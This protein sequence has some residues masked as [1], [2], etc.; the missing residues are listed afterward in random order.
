MAAPLDFGALYAEHRT[1]AY[2]AALALVPAGEADDIVAEA[3]ARVLAV[4]QAGGGPAGAFRPYLLAAVRNIARDRAAERRRVISVADLA[5]R[6]AA[7]PAGELAARAEE[8]RMVA[9]AFAS[10]PARWRA[11]L[12]QTEVE[13]QAPAALARASGMTPAAVSQL[14]V[15]A[16]AGLARAWERERGDQERVTAPLRILAVRKPRASR[17]TRVKGMP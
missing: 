6:H 12:W 5:P 13:G 1:A 8:L 11:V 17:L 4:M 3:F 9:R 10:L 2:R 15:R 16:R 14:A 7:P